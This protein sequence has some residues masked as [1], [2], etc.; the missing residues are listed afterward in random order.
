MDIGAAKQIKRDAQDVQDAQKPKARV[1][2]VL[3]IPK[4][5]HMLYLENPEDF[6]SAVLAFTRHCK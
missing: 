5:G 3:E 2:D 1:I 4:S 6:N